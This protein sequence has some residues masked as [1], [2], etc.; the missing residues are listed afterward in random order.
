MQNDRDYLSENAGIIKVPKER[1]EQ[2]QEAECNLWMKEGLWWGSDRNEE[3]AQS[4]LNYSVL[5][6]RKFESAIE[7]GCGPFTNLRLIAKACE[8][9]EI[10]LLDPLINN[11][12]DHPGCFYSRKALYLKEIAPLDKRLVAIRKLKSSSPTLARVLHRM[13]QATRG[14]GRIPLGR[15][16]PTAMESMDISKKYDLLVMI[17]V[18]EHC[19]DIEKIFSNILAV[20][21]PGSVFV[22]HDR[23]YRHEDVAKLTSKESFDAYHPLRVDKAIIENF[24]SNNFSC[25]YRQVQQPDTKPSKEASSVLGVNEEEVFFIGARN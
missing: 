5:N 13:V 9:Q 6:G 20:S 14:G 7:L 19:F 1:W 17:N 8:I 21:H 3:H 15:I 2:A 11:Y 12:L 18:L 10:D 23:F 24:L 16:L 4:F 22:F 25:I